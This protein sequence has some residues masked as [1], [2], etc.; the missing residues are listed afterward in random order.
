MENIGNKLKEKRIERGLTIEEVSK[1][2]RL[3]QKHIKA[4][5]DGNI[6]FFHDDLSYL[7]FFVKSYCEILDVD[8]EEVKDELRMNVKDYTTSFTNSLHLEHEEIEKHVAN[9]NKDKLSSI[10]KVNK[11]VRTRKKRRKPDVSLLS[12]IAIVV[13]V[14]MVIILTFV[15]Y[16]RSNTSKKP[17]IANDNQ[18]IAN[19]QENPIGIANPAEEEKKKK[20]EEAAK[21]AEKKELEVVKN[22]EKSYTIEN[23]KNGDELLFE[24]YFAGSNSGFS[25]SVDGKVLGEPKAE[26]YKYLTTAKGSIKVNKGSKIQ[27]YIGYLL[28]T[29]I[30]VNGKAVKIDDAVVNS[31]KAHTLEFTVAGKADEPAQ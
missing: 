12:L 25:A 9:A 14:V 16:L 17:P 11:N 13:V 7:R 30:K 5:E 31:G 4:L 28:K 26:V 10:N 27:I 8:F 23:V 29:E 20:E 3:T 22:G 6:E 18:P 1:K 15:V 19:V 24:V 2:T 21:E